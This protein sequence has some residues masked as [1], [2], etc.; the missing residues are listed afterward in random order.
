MRFADANGVTLGLAIQRRELD[1]FLRVLAKNQSTEGR[2]FAFGGKALVILEDAV[3]L[4][5]DAARFAIADVRGEFEAAIG[6]EALLNARAGN[7]V[8]HAFVEQHGDLVIFDIVHG[9]VHRHIRAGVMFRHAARQE[10]A[11]GGEQ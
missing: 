3:Y 5:L 6:R 10:Q 11:A 1:R 8:L 2:F 7:G 9:S 4:H